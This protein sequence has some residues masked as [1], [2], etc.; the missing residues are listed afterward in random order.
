MIVEGGE[1]EVSWLRFTILQPMRGK[2]K[3]ASQDP[4]ASNHLREAYVICHPHG[5]GCVDAAIRYVRPVHTM[6]ARWIDRTSWDLAFIS[7]EFVSAEMSHF[8]AW[9]RM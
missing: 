7:T 2:P 5:L 4:Y 9:L 8:L 1:P 3:N 6:F